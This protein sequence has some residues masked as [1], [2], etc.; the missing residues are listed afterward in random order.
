VAVGAQDRLEG[1][2]TEAAEATLAERK[3]VAVIDVLVAI[4]WLTGAAVDRWR[5]GQTECL[6]GA[7]SASPSDLSAALGAFERW[8][9]ARGLQPSE[10]DYLARTRERRPLQFSERAEPGI[11][12]TYRILWASPELS[13]AQRRH[14]VDKQSRPPDLVVIDAL[15]AWTCTECGGT[16]DLLFM[17]GDGPLCL[18]CAD[19]DELV[20]LPAGNT[21][22]SR[23][24]RKESELT[25]V[26]VRFSR[27]RGRYERQGLLIQAAALARAE[28]VCLADE[29]SRRARRK[30]EAERQPARDEAFHRAL[31]EE[32]ARL[33]PSCPPERAAEISHHA[34]LRGSGRVGRSAAGRALDPEALTLAV[35]ASVRH[36]DTSYDDLLMAGVP[37]AEARAQVRSKV[38][39][40]LEVWRTKVT[41]S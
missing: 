18:E 12:R 40:V 15:K 25:A 26:V 28:E 34:G 39:E 31:A 16:G 4:G 32:I 11:E 5:R 22:L 41:R 35:V 9:E 19:L 37:R 2:V 20:F 17:E 30:R 24:A 8:A 23:R 27:S 3:A 1:R 7:I 6:E 21:A 10:T 29:D 13:Q 14:L 38:E 36:L 33:F